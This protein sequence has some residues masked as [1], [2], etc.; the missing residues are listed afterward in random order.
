MKSNNPSLENLFLW[1]MTSDA[2]KDE[3]YRS[4]DPT[5]T[6]PVFPIVEVQ[7]MKHNKP[8]LP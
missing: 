6:P 5:I 4:G 2:I 7:K 8:E 3:K 1:S